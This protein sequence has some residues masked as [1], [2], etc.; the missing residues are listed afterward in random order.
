MLSLIMSLKFKEKITN[1][2]EAGREVIRKFSFNCETQVKVS[3]TL[4]L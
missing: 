2:I 4:G 3:L 1:C